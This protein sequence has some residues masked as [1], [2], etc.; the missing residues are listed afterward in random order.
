MKLKRF[1]SITTIVAM[2]VG[3][4]AACGGGKPASGNTAAASGET[5]A[6]GNKYQTTYGSK[7]FDNVTITVELFD[8]S[9]APAGSTI[10]DNRWTRYVNEQMNKVGITVEFLPVPR[11][12]EV[13][14]MQTLMATGEAPDITITYNYTYADE[15]YGKGGTWDLSEF[16]DGADQ[17][18]NLKKYLGDVVL[19]MGRRK[20]GALQGIVARRAT[21]ANTNM[22]IR[23]DLLDEVGAGIPT[24]PEELY[25]VL[26]KIKE[27]HPTGTPYAYFFSLHDGANSACFRNNMAMAFSQVANDPK[28]IDIGYNYDYYYDPGQ[29]EYFRYINKLYNA[30]LLDSEFYTT[31]TDTLHADIVNGE[32]AFYEINVNY[33]V[34]VLR[35][36]LLKTLKENIPTADMVSLPTLKNVFDG[37]QYT[38]DYSPG[39]LICI[40]PKTATEEQ[41]EACITYLDWLATQEGGYAIY[42]GFEGEHYN[43]V[44]G[45]P[46]VKDPAYNAN[47]KDW[48]RTDLFLVGNQGY[49]ATE[50]DFISCTGKENPDY[51]QYVLDNYHNAIVGN[52]QATTP[53]SSPI[54]AD[55]RTDLS[56]IAKEWVATI[57]TCIPEEFDANWEKWMKLAK[58]AGIDQVIEQR[59]AYFDEIY[60]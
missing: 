30:G 17:A 51:E 43:L 19:E 53:Y 57:A 28:K 38:A 33:N 18:Q 49:F 32:V 52:R 4:L 29:K 46:V 8:R 39:G 36:T 16:V 27:A 48:I 6:P 44:D 3:T 11:T 14:K 35:G 12:D 22:I 41:V 21:T 15:Y 55:L 59:T 13:P 20:D 7:Q 37:K 25:Q 40:V 47:D 24:T 56:V 34:D 45:V 2:T 50:E 1:I 31:T 60:Q 26:L 58:D 5:S 10:T 42:H 54:E 9:N 23:N